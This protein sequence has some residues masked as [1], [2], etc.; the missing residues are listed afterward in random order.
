MQYYS[1]QHTSE[2]LEIPKDTLRYYDK[3]RLVSPSRNENSYRCYSEQDLLDLK[4]LEAMKYADFTLSE[5]RKFFA[6]Q[7]ALP[8]SED[9]EIIERLFEDKK[10]GYRQK[11]KTYRAM[12]KLV[13]KILEEKNQTSQPDEMEKANELLISIFQE[14]RNVQHAK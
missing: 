14:I 13:D 5:I 1:I 8:S 7:R 3:L 2:L 10:G 12:I 4:Y 6:I 11:I 9:C